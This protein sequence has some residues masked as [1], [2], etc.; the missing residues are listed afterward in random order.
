[1]LNP[2][3]DDLNCAE[4][5]HLTVKAGGYRCPFKLDTLD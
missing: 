1:M 4:F 5:R 3:E 2:R